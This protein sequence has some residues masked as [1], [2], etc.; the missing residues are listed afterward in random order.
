MTDN[1]LTIGYRAGQ[2]DSEAWKALA[3]IVRIYELANEADEDDDWYEVFVA[4][5]SARKLLEKRKT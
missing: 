4:V 1:D 5:Q 2:E 3:E